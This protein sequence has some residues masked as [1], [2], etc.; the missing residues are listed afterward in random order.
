MQSVHADDDD[1]DCDDANITLNSQLLS[2]EFLRDNG[3]T[4]LSRDIH[5]YM[6]DW[7][8]W[9]LSMLTNDND[10]CQVIYWLR[11]SEN[12][13]VYLNYPIWLNWSNDGNIGI[14]FNY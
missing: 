3:T 1:D 10:Q 6:G 7:K 8:E 13:D 11:D 2:F 12:V 9:P 14:V 5:Y 4:V